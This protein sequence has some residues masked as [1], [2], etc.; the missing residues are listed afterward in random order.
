VVANSYSSTWAR[1]LLRVPEPGELSLLALALAFLF[2]LGPGFA[3]A[4][5]GPPDFAG[6]CQQAAGR[7]AGVAPATVKVRGKYKNQDGR[8]VLDF[9]LD[10]GRVGKCVAKADAAIEDVKLGEAAP[11]A[12]PR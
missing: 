7:K 11:P 1:Q 12:P 2:A 8:Y 4:Q 5:S 10:D 9:K 6:Q 3:R